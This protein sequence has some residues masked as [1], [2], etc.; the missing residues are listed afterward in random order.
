MS[1]GRI[2][3]C[4]VHRENCGWRKLLLGADFPVQAHSTVVTVPHS[5]QQYLQYSL[6]SKMLFSQSG[7]I[8]HSSYK[9]LLIECTRRV[10]C[11]AKPTSAHSLFSQLRLTAPTCALEI[12][13][14]RARTLITWKSLKGHILLGALH[15]KMPSVQMLQSKIQGG[16]YVSK[17]DSGKGRRLQPTLTQLNTNI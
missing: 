14:A 11:L 10:K 3:K 17:H 8:K 16:K 5:M 15:T 2:W 1:G 6:F 4:L 9:S 13:Q 7:R 12:R